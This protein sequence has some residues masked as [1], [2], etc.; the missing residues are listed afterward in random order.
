MFFYIQKI[1][2][3]IAFRLQAKGKL[4]SAREG[5]AEKNFKNYGCPYNFFL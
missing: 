4:F 2:T 1:L 5:F 3:A